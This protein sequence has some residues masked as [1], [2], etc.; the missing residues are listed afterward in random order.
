MG[1]EVQP[2]RVSAVVAKPVIKQQQSQEVILKIRVAG[3]ADP[4]YVELELPREAMTL[5]YLTV[6]ACEELGVEADQIERL[7][8]DREVARLTDYQ[9][10]ELVLRPSSN[11]H[12]EMEK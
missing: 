2:R 11:G 9:E 5:E 4:D 7:R 8:K 3:G 12:E 1:M 10:V 6:A